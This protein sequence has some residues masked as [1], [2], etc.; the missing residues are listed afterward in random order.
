[1]TK[2]NRTILQ[3]TLVG[4]C[5]NVLLSAFKLIAGL[6]GHSAAMVSDA[7]HSLSDV[8][9]TAIAFTGVKLAKAD[10]DKDHPYGHERFEQAASIILAGIL[11]ATGLGIGYSGIKSI[12]SNSGNVPGTIA[13]AAA[14][15]SIAVKEAMFWYTRYCAKKI[16]SSAF[17]ADAWHHRS[18]ALSSVGALFGIIGA[19][20]GYPVFDSIASVVICL[21]ILK[22]AFDIFREALSKMTDKSASEEFESELRDFIKSHEGVESIDLLKTRKFGE[23]VYVDLEIGIDGEMKLVDA[24]DI[25]AQVHAA[26]EKKY[27]EVKHVMIHMNP[28]DKQRL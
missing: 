14:L 4:V 27:P 16:N 11:L 1:M 26:V 20:L 6:T 18:D 5:G 13:L 15:V 12:S 21:F 7:I 23:K 10:A 9:A 8:F 2:N 28:V 19:R 22:V 17:M 25:S 3:V 24:H